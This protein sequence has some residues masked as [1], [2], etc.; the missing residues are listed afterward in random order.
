MDTTVRANLPSIDQ[1]PA[2]VW[3]SRFP[4]LWEITPDVT[5]PPQSMPSLTDRGTM[6]PTSGYVLERINHS[7]IEQ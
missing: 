3:V 2:V 7:N 6:P 4:P 1:T 5:Q